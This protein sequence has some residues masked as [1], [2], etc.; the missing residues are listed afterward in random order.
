MNNMEKEV[1]QNRAFKKI[2]ITA[3][4]AQTVLAEGDDTAMYGFIGR[5]CYRA[6]LVPEQGESTQQGRGGLT[7]N[8]CWAMAK[9]SA[10][11]RTE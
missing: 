7:L 6:T 1:G 10:Y 2:G 5:H 8:E 4:M 11:G 9:H 3:M